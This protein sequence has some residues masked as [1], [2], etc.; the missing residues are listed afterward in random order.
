MDKKDAVPHTGK[1][2]NKQT[3][4]KCTASYIPV[5]WF[6]CKTTYYCIYYTIRGLF[7]LIVFSGLTN[8]NSKAVFLKSLHN[9]QINLNDRAGCQKY[10]SAHNTT[11][12]NRSL[13]Q[14]AKGSC[15]SEQQAK[16]AS[17]NNS[18]TE[19]YWGSAEAKNTFNTGKS[20]NNPSSGR[21]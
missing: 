1:K 6:I 11:E 13:H 15:F 19:H 4:G 20:P 7:G 5:L 14:P 2:T 16:K 10:S 17:C 21:Y 8:S 18:N 3:K 12:H 9:F